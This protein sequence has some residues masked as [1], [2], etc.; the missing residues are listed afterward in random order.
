M[1]HDSS[2]NLIYIYLVSSTPFRSVVN[3]EHNYYSRIFY[4]LYLLLILSKRL[5]DIEDTLASLF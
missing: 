1:K 2:R 4:V 5:G 3:Y